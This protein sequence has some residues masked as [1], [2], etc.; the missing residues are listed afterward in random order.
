MTWYSYTE[1]GI[2]P[3]LEI[4]V[5]LSRDNTCVRLDDT[6]VHRGNCNTL[7]E[8][9]G[10]ITETHGYTPDTALSRDLDGQCFV[11]DGP[12]VPAIFHTTTCEFCDRNKQDLMSE[13]T[14]QQ[15]LVQGQSC[16][17]GHYLCSHCY[18]Q[19]RPE[20]SYVTPPNTP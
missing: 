12:V 16:V 7:L 20:Q 9:L 1:A 2:H 19:K 18:T 17:H 13:L 14:E 8:K 3:T 5:N 11:C 15:R 10:T 4:T 6:F